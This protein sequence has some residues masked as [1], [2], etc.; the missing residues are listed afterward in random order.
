MRVHARGFYAKNPLAYFSRK[1]RCCTAD[2]LFA[3]F[4][5]K[6]RDADRWRRMQRYSKSMNLRNGRFLPP[7]NLQYFTD[8]HRTTYFPL[9]N[10]HTN[11]TL[12]TSA[13]LRLAIQQNG[14]CLLLLAKFCGVSSRYLFANREYRMFGAE[15]LCTWCV[16]NVVLIYSYNLPVL[17]FTLSN[18]NI[19]TKL[20]LLQGQAVTVSAKNHPRL[21]LR[22]FSRNPCIRK[23]IHYAA[24]ESINNKTFSYYKINTYICKWLKY[25]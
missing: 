25:R 21:R 11:R 5:T 16:Q 15:L 1:K 2:K 6:A 10:Y 8:C 23:F 12:G 3:F 13:T 19:I 14:G 22:Y 18:A 4:G 17:W 20:F 9:L 24:F 7:A